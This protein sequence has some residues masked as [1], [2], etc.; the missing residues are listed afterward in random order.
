MM[1]ASRF[2]LVCLLVLLAG[3][4]TAFVALH[5]R[6]SDAALWELVKVVI[7]VD[8]VVLLIATADLCRPKR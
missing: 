5:A 6:A 3:L 1:T 4:G 7:G 8:L 2:R